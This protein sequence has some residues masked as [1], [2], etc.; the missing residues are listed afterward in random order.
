MSR[1]GVAFTMIDDETGK[2]TTPKAEDMI[3]LRAQ[4]EQEALEEA[5]ALQP[6]DTSILTLY[7]DG[8]SLKK[9]WRS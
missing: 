7:K 2:E 3:D 1:Y 8:H 4:T 6:S 5:R 9:Y